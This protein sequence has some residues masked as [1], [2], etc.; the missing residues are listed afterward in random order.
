LRNHGFLLTGD[1][2]TLSPA[3]DMNPVETG[4]GLSLN[5]SKTDNAQNLDV[6]IEVAP[7]FRL[8]SK[9]ADEIVHAV[10]KGVSKWNTIAEKTGIS[11]SERDAMAGAFRF[12]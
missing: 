1:G 11:R 9:N 6:A 2:W 10:R 5:I 7:Y 12:A 4:D 8:S 3:Y